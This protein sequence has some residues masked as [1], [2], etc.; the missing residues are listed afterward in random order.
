[1]KIRYTLPALAFVLGAGAVLSLHAQEPQ[2][3]KVKKSFEF[4]MDGSNLSPELLRRMSGGDPEVQKQL[5]KAYEDWRNAGAKGPFRF[6]YESS[7]PAPRGMTPGKQIPDDENFSPGGS[8][9]RQMEEM[10][11]RMGLP[12]GGFGAPESPGSP[13]ELSD[14]MMRRM[15]EFFGQPQVPGQQRSPG[16]KAPGGQGN[17]AP[18]GDLLERMRQFQGG[19]GSPGGA[20]GFQEMLKRMGQNG[21]PGESSAEASRHSKH[22]RAVLAEWRTLVK[23]AREST[24][25]I[26]I[27]DRQVALGTIVTADGYAI[28]KNSEAKADNVE[29][30]F[31]DG[32]IVKAKVVDRQEAYD[33][34]LIKLE[35]S[36]LT[37]A[38]VQNAEPPVGTLVAAVGMDEDPSAV[39]VISVAARSLSERSKG[40]LGI[41]FDMT[42]KDAGVRI[43]EVLANAAAEK[44]G[45]KNGDI[46][47]SVNGNK[48]EFA[49]Q[50]QK[51]V[52]DLKPGDKV[53]VQYLREGKEGDAE[54]PLGSR[55]DLLAASN[56][57][58]GE[59]VLDP[60]ARM[61][62]AL[63]GNSSGYP[64][65]LQCD[66]TVNAND[67]GAPVVDVD[68]NVVGISIAR[69]ERV[70]T[71]IIPG[72]VVAMLLT[73]IRSGEFT[74]AKDADTLKGE[75]HDADKAL[76]DAESAL[77]DAQS[78]K[79]K[80]EGALKKL[81]AQ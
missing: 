12:D 34:A 69:A 18:L 9:K 79:A 11:R 49:A 55:Q 43:E 8:A 59:R 72:K 47:T 16:R 75:M 5:L 64:S 60:T 1:M 4:N 41:K 78:R 52:T 22:H 15:Q 81:P 31:H 37:P 17:G 24:V 14:E 30:E 3:P 46:I 45:L 67:C 66:L 44:G 2:L 35:A 65:A 57:P 29:C 51:L 6:K 10:M 21:I 19:D 70:S 61:G 33:L 71:Y 56:I 7:G 68:G 20:G 38:N 76:R 74:L 77:K 28:T 62:S 50:V 63:S 80:A 23:T 73:N 48:V 27:D 39:G 54:F 36:G 58:V 25:R 13:E 32:R 53:K 26:L 42:D 40:A